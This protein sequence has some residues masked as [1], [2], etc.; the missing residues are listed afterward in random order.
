MSIDL[1]LVLIAVFAS[2]ALGAAA[3]ASLALNWTTPEQRQIRRLS[4]R[5]GEGILAQLHL[6][7][8]PAPW[9]KRFQQIVPKSPKEMTRLRRRLS[10][11][12]YR[13]LA[14]SR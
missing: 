13:S 14:A 8:A 10:T 11:A 1:P 5:S 6:T 3:I 12:G 7:E 9:V 4:Q 2:V